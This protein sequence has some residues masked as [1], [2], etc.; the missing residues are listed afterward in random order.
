MQDTLLVGTDLGEGTLT[1]SG[2]PRTIREW[3]RGTKLED[4][5]LV[6]EGEKKDVSVSVSYYRDGPCRYENYHRSITFYTYEN[7]FKVNGELV[8]IQAQEDA[9]VDTYQDHL[10][11]LIK[12]DWGKHKAGSLLAVPFNAMIQKQAD[13]VLEEN[14]KYVTVLFEPTSVA[15]LEGYSDTKNF[16]ILTILDDVKTTLVF[17]SYDMSSQA[18]TKKENIKSSG[19]K[20]ESIS[21]HGFDKDN[22]DL[23]WTTTNSYDQP[24]T[25]SLA[26]ATGV[27]QTEV[28]K[29]TPHFY[30]AE[31]V[32]IRQHKA[33]S[34]DGT[35]INYFEVYKGT[36][37]PRNLPTVLYGYGGFEISLTPG[38]S[39]TVGIA[40]LEKGYVYCVAN[41]R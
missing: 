4:A 17:W 5:P 20:I 33:K 25:L 36:G 41:I 19:N 38:Y 34:K 2:Y 6:F 27:K 22:S 13:I 30:D 21:A 10:L 32:T 14:D 37:E 1:D 24:T 8:K 9:E 18:W 23:F 40:W 15:S 12:T 11:F 26:D 35:M 28:Y 3:K 29:Q 16:L 31:N 39:A 7:F